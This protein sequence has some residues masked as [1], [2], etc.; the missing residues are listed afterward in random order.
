[1]MTL[2]TSEPGGRSQ[3]SCRF[4]AL[5]AHAPSS[6]AGAAAGNSRAGLQQPEFSP[7]GYCHDRL[8]SHATSSWKRRKHTDLMYGSKQQANGPAAV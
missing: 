4:H 6:A 2:A 5:M 3:P 8:S 7:L 1:M